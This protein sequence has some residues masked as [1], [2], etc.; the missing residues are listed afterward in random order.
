MPLLDGD[1]M[2]WVDFECGGDGGVVDIEFKAG[3]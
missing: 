1:C 2:H 3:N